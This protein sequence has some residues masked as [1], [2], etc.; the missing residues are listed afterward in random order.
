MILFLQRGETSGGK[1]T[2]RKHENRRR[3]QR[4]KK[5]KEKEKSGQMSGRESEIK[6]K[7][8]ENRAVHIKEFFAAEPSFIMAPSS[9]DLSAFVSRRGG[10]EIRRRLVPPPNRH[11]RER[12]V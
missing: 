6:K 1:P 2:D 8:K 11:E 10:R 7:K 4:R 12:K 3:R 9:I 5:K